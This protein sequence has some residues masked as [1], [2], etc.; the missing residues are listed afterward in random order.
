LTI[1]RG[2]GMLSPKDTI[3]SCNGTTVIDPELAS[4]RPSAVLTASGK[5]ATVVGLIRACRPQQWTKNVLLFFGLIFALKLTNLGL[6]LRALIGFFVFCASSSGVYLINDLADVEK[7]RQHP[8][9]R[10]RPLAAGIITSA[11]AITLASVLFVVSIVVSYL[12]GPVFAALVVFYVA[13]MLLYSSTS[14]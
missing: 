1:F 13:M 3:L 2:V 9:K 4:A 11:Q 8:K 5:T 14:C 10:N 12:M 7:D 6:D